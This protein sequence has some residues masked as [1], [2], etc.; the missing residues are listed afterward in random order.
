MS[1]KEYLEDTK[2]DINSSIDYDT[3]SA[4]F[5]YAKILE[6]ETE[7]PMKLFFNS[8]F[9][10]NLTRFE[11]LN[12][13]EFLGVLSNNTIVGNFLLNMVRIVVDDNPDILFDLENPDL[14]DN[15]PLHKKGEDVVHK[16]INK[17]GVSLKLLFE[18]YRWRDINIYDYND[19]IKKNDTFEGECYKVDGLSHFWDIEEI[20]RRVIDYFLEDESSSSSSI[21]L[22]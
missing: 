21:N 12:N 16:Y 17:N 7:G 3:L 2:I 15:H 10:S 9:D 1:F 14:I 4:L 20:E 22:I 5:E 18:T 6:K 11:Y 19:Y 8:E 13:K